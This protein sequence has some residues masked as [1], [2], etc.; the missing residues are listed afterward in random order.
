MIS[1]LSLAVEKTELNDTCKPVFQKYNFKEDVWFP[2]GSDQFADMITNCRCDEQVFYRL[3]TVPHM[4]IGHYLH[5]SIGNSSFTYDTAKNVWEDCKL[6]ETF[7]S[8]REEKSGFSPKNFYGRSVWDRAID[9]VVKKRK[10][11][12]CGGGGGGGPPFGFRG[13]GILWNG[14]IILGIHYA[15]NCAVVAFLFDDKTGRI[16]RSQ[17]LCLDNLVFDGLGLHHGARLLDLGGDGY[18]C[19]VHFL[20]DRNIDS[21]YSFQI[22][23]VT[24][25]VS[26][27]PKQTAAAPDDHCDYD[28]DHFV[29]CKFVRKEFVAKKLSE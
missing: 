12:K 6:F 28:D 3:K 8:E 13:R 16:E 9:V 21:A 27:I 4:V 24:F 22:E 11:A 19:L 14:N 10:I 29:D 17:R 18:F 15:P 2:L 20:S 1:Y 23:L 5:V 7:W 26:R 25:Q